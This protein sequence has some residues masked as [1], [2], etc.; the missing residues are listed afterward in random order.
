[1]DAATGVTFTLNFW[2]RRAAHYDGFGSIDV[3]FPRRRKGDR[4]FA[5]A[6]LGSRDW[7]PIT[8]TDA[9]VEQRIMINKG[10]NDPWSNTIFFRMNLSWTTDAPATYAAN[11]QVSFPKRFRDHRATLVRAA[12]RFACRSSPIS[13]GAGVIR[14]AQPGAGLSSVVAGPAA[15]DSTSDI[16][17]TTK[18]SRF[19]GLHAATRLSRFPSQMRSR[20]HPD[21]SV[22]IMPHG[23]FTD[24][25][26][27]LALVRP[28]QRTIASG[29]DNRNSGQCDCRPPRCCRRCGSPLRARLC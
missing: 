2:Q 3:G 20:N 8:L 15:A 19:Q 1:V 12:R 21:V 24:P 17:I 25:R 23:D 4:R 29:S 26:F 16:E 5:V 28:A 13:G 10:L 11:Y 9:Q 14:R 7:N 27:P 18:T 6:P 22:E